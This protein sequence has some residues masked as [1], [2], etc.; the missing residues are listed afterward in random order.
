MRRMVNI[1]VIVMLCVS[2]C[3]K[4]YTPAAITIN[5]NYLVIDGVINA[6]PNGSTTILLSRTKNLTDSVK[7]APENG[8][9]VS[10]E[11]ETGG[12]FPLTAQGNG[13]Y[14]SNPLNLVAS[15]KYRLRILTKDGSAYQSDFVSVKQTPPIDSLS[16]RQDTLTKDILIYAHTHDPNNQTHFYRWD[17]VETWQ[18]RAAFQASWGMNGTRIYFI[19]PFDQV[20][21]QYNC[22]GTVNSTNIAIA[23]SEALSQDLISY[24]PVNRV[25]QNAEKLMV[26][27]SI[28]VRQY[29]LTREAYRYWQIIEKSTQ[30]TGTVFDPQ[31]AQL[32]GNIHC[33]SNPTEPV[34]GYVSVS[35]ITEKRIF[36]DHRDVV[37]WKYVDLTPACEIAF[38]FQDPNDFLHFPYP[39]TTYAIYYFQT[40]GGMAMAK[41]RCVDCRRRGGTNLKPSFWQ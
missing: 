17:N 35:Y 5:Y 26:R 3:K 14:T 39:D 41:K 38:G 19:D 31:P 37:E 16:W 33:T 18:Y 4:P 6:N 32:V 23:S 34:I 24:A 1:L 7:P 2:A 25:R 40:G 28:N 12:I 27:Y 13:A 36:I 9:Q 20:L 29:G 8:A 15:A 22:W 21:Q 30:Q 10:I 11:G